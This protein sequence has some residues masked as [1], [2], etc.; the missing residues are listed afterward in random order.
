MRIIIMRFW[1]GVRRGGVVVFFFCGKA[2]FC[3]KAPF[4][5]KP[6]F[7]FK[8]KFVY[9]HHLKFVYQP[10]YYYYIHTYYTLFSF[11]FTNINSLVFSI[12][13]LSLSFFLSSYE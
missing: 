6:C 12:S 10:S 8:K 7:F 9:F 11:P 3:E 4:C 1:G 13:L 5:R 2:L